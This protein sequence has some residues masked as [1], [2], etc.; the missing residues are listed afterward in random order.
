V[1]AI[2]WKT[3]VPAA[4]TFLGGGFRGVALGVQKA[5]SYTAGGM[6]EMH[7]VQYTYAAW[8]IRFD[9]LHRERKAS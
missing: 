6:F 5:H 7:D 2:Q 1:L 8:R 4:A 3:E 9:G